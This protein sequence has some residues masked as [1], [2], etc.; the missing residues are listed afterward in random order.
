MLTSY[1]DMC[2]AMETRLIEFD[3]ETRRGTANFNW[4]LPSRRTFDWTEAVI[5]KFA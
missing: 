3:N 4:L 2:E 5:L 1:Q